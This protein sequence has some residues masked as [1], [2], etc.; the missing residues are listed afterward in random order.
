MNRI[1]FVVTTLAALL[2]GCAPE[3]KDEPDQRVTP[4]FLTE[5]RF[6]ER[7]GFY[8]IDR[9]PVGD[10]ASLLGFELKDMKH[11]PGQPRFSDVR[12]VQIRG[13][14]FVVR[15]L[16]ADKN[17]VIRGS[18]DDPSCPASISV[19]LVQVPAEQESVKSDGR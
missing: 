2:Q 13:L 7:D 1:V 12:I 16:R 19:S 8:E 18:L 10:A 3:T 17:G 14:A 9:I 6:Q 5:H 4:A 15:S 11:T